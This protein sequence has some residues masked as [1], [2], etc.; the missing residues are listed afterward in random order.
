[1]AYRFIR[2]AS[3]KKALRNLKNPMAEKEINDFIDTKLDGCENPR[4]RSLH[5]K[6]LKGTKL[7]GQCRY[8][9]GDYR[10]IAIIDD[11]DVVII[12]VETAHRK[13]IYRRR[14]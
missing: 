3:L 5:Y 2:L 11:T 12:G 8:R 10:L 7:A 9:I 13:E 1:M 14:R 4:D 6:P